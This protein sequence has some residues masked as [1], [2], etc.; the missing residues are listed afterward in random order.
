MEIDVESSTKWEKT[1]PKKA[2]YKLPG[3]IAGIVL[4]LIAVYWLEMHRPWPKGPDYGAL[5]INPGHMPTNVNGST[6][7]PPSPAFT[8]SRHWDGNNGIIVTNSP[9]A[10]VKNVSVVNNYGRPRNR[11][12]RWG[13]VCSL[14]RPVGYRQ[15]GL[16]R[17]RLR[18]RQHQLRRRP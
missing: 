1:A 15:A 11:P 2:N 17:K 3:M 12:K 16:R 14:Q 10:V 18:R 6:N 7:P 5:L 13:A 8:D 9:G 4:G